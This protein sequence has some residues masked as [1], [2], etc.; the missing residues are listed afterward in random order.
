MVPG[1]SWYP[2]NDVP[3]N[4]VRDAGGLVYAAFRDPTEIATGRRAE[5]LLAALD[6][7]AGGIRWTREGPVEVLAALEDGVLVQEGQAVAAISAGGAVRWTRPIPARQFVT[8]RDT[9]VDGRRGRIYLGR[10]GVTPGITAI[11][12]ATGAAI[13]RT[14]PGDFARL[15]SVGRS[16]RVYAAIDRRGRQGV[17]GLRL[18]SGGVAWE[19]RT[20]LPAYDALELADGDVA[21]SA[22]VRYGPTTRDPLTVRV[23]G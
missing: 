10:R 14:P 4:V 11:D 23:P 15:L 20:G 17:R 3:P 21:V 22:G 1:W 6:P 2:E 13:W 18:A 12:A 19:R 16:G 7:A 9:A 5:G 8:A